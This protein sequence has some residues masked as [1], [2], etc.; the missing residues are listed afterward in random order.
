MFPHSPTIAGS[1]RGSI[2]EQGGSDKKPWGL[3]K[4]ATLLSG[5][6]S[7]ISFSCHPERAPASFP[8]QI[9][10]KKANEGSS[11]AG[12]LRYRGVLGIF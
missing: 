6:L 7:E 3:Q 9:A 5:L 11:T 8:S 12:C 1:I 10:G 2:V 4:V